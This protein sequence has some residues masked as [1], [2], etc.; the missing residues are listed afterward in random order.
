MNTSVYIPQEIARRLDRYIASGNST[1][2]S[3]NAFIVKAIEQ[4]LNELEIKENWSPEIL[5]WQGGD[6][7]ILR[8]EFTGFGHDLEL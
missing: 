3:K 1:E 4:R 2:S 6:I 7:S 5:D 8:E